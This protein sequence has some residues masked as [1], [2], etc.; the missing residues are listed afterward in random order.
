MNFSFSFSKQ[1]EVKGVCLRFQN[2]LSGKYGNL[3][4]V[5]VVVLFFCRLCNVYL[6]ILLSRYC[7]T[8]FYKMCF[9]DL[10]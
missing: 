9:V 2:N 8:K 10:F 7:C 6:S 5:F 3:T 4:L 1:I